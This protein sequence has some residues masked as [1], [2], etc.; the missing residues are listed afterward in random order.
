MSLCISVGSNNNRGVVYV[1]NNTAVSFVKAT[2][3]S[4]VSNLS[5]IACSTALDCIAVGLNSIIYTNNAGVTWNSSTSF[6]QN[7]D[8]TSA[9]CITEINC[10]VVGSKQGD[11]TSNTAVIISSFNNGYTFSQDKY[12]NKISGL[13]AVSCFNQTDCIGVGGDVV[14]VSANGGSTWTSKPMARG[15]PPLSS[16]SCVTNIVCIA[17][18]PNSVRNNSAS[19][20]SA[21][22]IYTIDGGISFS[23]LNLGANSAFVSSIA[24][25]LTDCIALGPSPTVNNLTNEFDISMSPNNM[26]SIKQI[27]S[28]PVGILV[29]HIN[30]S[31]SAGFY[32][33]GIKDYNPVIYK[34]SA[35]STLKV[36]N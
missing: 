35:S 20:I 9:T 6:I 11:F 22:A 24:C 17:V 18:G 10:I 23:Y 15:V 14:V 30:S 36:G 7:V 25:N 16:I 28:T 8:Y 32:G 3:P 29:S 1:S 12:L 21:N 31:V 4:Y 27:N 2:I 5:S 34:L 33:L 19:S 13:Q 26:L